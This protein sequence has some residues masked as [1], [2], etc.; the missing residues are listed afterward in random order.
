MDF[1]P[2]ISCTNERT[3]CIFEKTNW[4][5]SACLSNWRCNSLSHISWLHM[6]CRPYL[7]SALIYEVQN[8]HAAWSWTY[9]MGIKRCKPL[10]ALHMLAT[11]NLPFF[12]WYWPEM[13][14]YRIQD[15]DSVKRL[16][17][18]QRSITRATPVNWYN[19]RPTLLCQ[20]KTYKYYKICYLGNSFLVRG[21][22]LNRGLFETQWF[23]VFWLSQ[24]TR[25]NKTK[26]LQNHLKE[27]C[28][29]LFLL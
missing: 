8:V 12:R 15:R 7:I 27:N 18:A 28:Y 22:E 9:R 4:L 21:P 16:N 1:F 20:V 2:R 11:A 14:L 26:I 24:K 17:R 6:H 29:M 10:F 23:K 3:S 25:L 13:D 19:I 5:K